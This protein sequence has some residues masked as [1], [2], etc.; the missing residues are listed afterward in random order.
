MI[1]ST[2]PLAPIRPQLRQPE[3]GDLVSSTAAGATLG[4]VLLGCSSATGGGPRL[5][6]LQR[7]P[8]QEALGSRKGDG[9]ARH[10]KEKLGSG[11]A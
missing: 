9:T 4:A 8:R 10:F 11:L 5:R 1:A 2:G 6:W 3:S 7:S